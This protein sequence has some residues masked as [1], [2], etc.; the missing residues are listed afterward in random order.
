MN[1][2]PV[3]HGENGLV[4]LEKIRLPDNKERFG[5]FESALNLD[6][7]CEL[8]SGTQGQCHLLDSTKVFKM[9]NSEPEAV[10]ASYLMNN[11]NKL[12]PAIESVFM[13]EDEFGKFYG[14]IR[15]EAADVFDEIND[16]SGNLEKIFRE[17]WRYFDNG[18]LEQSKKTPI[19][20]LA[21]RYSPGYLRK[22][23]RIYNDLLDFRNATQIE[24]QDLVFSNIGRID[25]KLIIRDFGRNTIMRTPHAARAIQNLQDIQVNSLRM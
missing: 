10:L 3:Q 13:M 4:D 5:M 2:D 25:D 24:V 17:L 1:C 22:I 8:G 15:E 7:L 20:A 19:Y 11:P 18:Y 23:E 21:E 9:T 6:I 16:E 12:F 14:F